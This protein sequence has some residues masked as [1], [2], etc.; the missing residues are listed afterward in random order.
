MI[1]LCQVVKGSLKYSSF[2]P[3]MLISQLEFH[4][5]MFHAHKARNGSVLQGK[6]RK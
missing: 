4:W 5:Y 1:N 6:K 2:R 3:E